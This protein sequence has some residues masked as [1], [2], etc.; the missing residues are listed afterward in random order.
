M[1]SSDQGFLL[2]PAVIDI[3]SHQ[4][5]SGVRK[6][7][8]LATVVSVVTFVIAMI[9]AEVYLRHRSTTIP[10]YPYALEFYT[11]DG[12]KV[13]TVV[14]SLK[15][16]LD[17]FTI[18][19]NLPSQHTSTFTIN[20][21]GL[22]GEEGVERDSAP[23]IIFLGGSSAFGLGARTDQETIPYLLEQSIKSHRVLNAGVVGFL[24][25]QELTYLVTQLID[26]RPAVVVAYDGWN[27]L[28]DTIP[29]RSANELGFNNT[30][31]VL[32]DQLVLNYQTQVSP[33][34]SLSRLIDATSAKSLVCT[35][36]AQALR[37]YRY[38]KAVAA[39]LAADPS[40]IKNKAL[41]NSVV[42]NYVGNLRKM[43]L[44]SRASGAEFI[45]VFQPELGQRLSRTSEEQELLNLGIGGNN[46]YQ[47]QFP[48][49]YG[50]FLAIAKPLLT[51]D[52]VEWI[53]V[54]ES[55][56]FQKSPDSL[57]ADVV[58]TNRRGNEIVSE[59]ISPRLQIL[60]NYRNRVASE[61]QS[62]PRISNGSIPGSK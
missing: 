28:F 34:E 48:A 4:E 27:D 41:L 54:N 14:G 7:L 47:D 13:S 36:F 11:H 25:G 15:L 6:K 30:F 8:L 39:Q 17:P 38:R 50:E 56:A 61:P 16:S 58:H 45:V 21:K 18:Y 46:R 60:L 40:G 59:I 42:E 37:A 33:Y 31:F 22:R 29:Q 53:D 32:E 62:P 19:R 55:M 26:Y 49:L 5:D 35:R 12:R 51:R 20:S 43:S 52:G 23:K 3:S 9:A 2:T 10:V 1:S 44:F 57:F 24:S